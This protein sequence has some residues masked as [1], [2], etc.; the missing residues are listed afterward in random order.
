[1]YMLIN[2]DVIPENMLKYF[3]KNNF[4]PFL[5][6]SIILLPLPSQVNYYI[7]KQ[8]YILKAIA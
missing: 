5:L 4:M 6:L 8:Y 3:K 1:M 2:L 7:Y